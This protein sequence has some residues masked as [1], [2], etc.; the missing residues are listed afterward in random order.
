[1][2]SNISGVNGI[3]TFDP[4]RTSDADQYTCTATINNAEVGIVGLSGNDSVVLTVA[5]GC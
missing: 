2:S 1:M 4:V 3:V 5:G